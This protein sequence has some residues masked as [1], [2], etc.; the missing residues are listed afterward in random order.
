LHVKGTA[1][2]EK[3][4]EVPSIVVLAVDGMVHLIL[5]QDPKVPDKAPVLGTEVVTLLTVLLA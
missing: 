4:T 5:V 3:S 1:E 2:V